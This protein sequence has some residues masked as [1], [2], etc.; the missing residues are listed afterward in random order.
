MD[1]QITKS[2]EVLSKKHTYRQSVQPKTSS[3]SIGNKTNTLRMVIETI[4]GLPDM[5][6]DAKTLD[7]LRAINPL[8]VEYPETYC[9]PIVED[10]LW[11]TSGDFFQE[12]EAIL[13]IKKGR[14]TAFLSNDWPSAIR[15][16]SILECIEELSDYWGGYTGQKK[17]YV[18]KKS[19]SSGGGIVPLKLSD[20]EKT[21]KKNT[22]RK[23]HY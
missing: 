14:Q 5:S 1:F 12:S 6:G 18:Y 10:F 15:F 19:T 7:L 13:N 17:A 11:K 3:K 9:K 4:K 8:M 16:M 23:R 20:K 21:R 2:R 22:R